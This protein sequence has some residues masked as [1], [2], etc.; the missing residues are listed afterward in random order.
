MSHNST[1]ENYNMNYILNF[2]LNLVVNKF[3]TKL[4]PLSTV[5]YYY[6][7]LYAMKAFSCYCVYTLHLKM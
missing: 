2:T 4:L 5:I 7:K 3:N 6:V 1:L